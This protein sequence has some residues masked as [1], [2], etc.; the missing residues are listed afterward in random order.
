MRGDAFIMKK[1]I[2]LEDEIIKNI[3]RIKQT[4]GNFGIAQHSKLEEPDFTV[5]H[6]IDDNARALI[7]ISRNSKEDNGLVK[8]LLKCLYESK[9]QDGW[10][11]NYRMSNGAFGRDGKLDV[12]SA[13]QDCYGRTL[14]ALA[15]FINSDYE[16][17]DRFKTKELFLG[18]LS[19]IS[20]LSYPMSMAFAGIALSKY[21]EHTSDEKILRLAKGTAKKLAKLYKQYS[22]EVWKGFDDKY[23]YCAARLPQSMILL[24][25]TLKDEQYTQIGIASLD[26]LIQNLFDSGGVF[27]AIGN[28]NPDT[29]EI[30]TSWL[31][32]YSIMAIYDEQSIEAGCMVEACRDASII[33][34]E[35]K[36]IQYTKNALQWFHGKN[37]A[38]IRMVKDNGAVYDAIN[39]PNSVNKNCGAESVISYGL[40][41]SS[42]NTLK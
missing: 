1:E 6:S 8:T 27:H 37:S 34:G 4:S 25:G 9:R 32:K 10:F 20:K 35:A 16:E 30:E 7:I 14:W 13:L 11:E 12:P 3:R 38:G 18:S 28:G 15:E 5:P 24:G 36:Y 26:F 33:T 29:N 19:N 21:L 41:L 39:G 17:S 40:A 23:T 22:N 2:E 31:R 42:I